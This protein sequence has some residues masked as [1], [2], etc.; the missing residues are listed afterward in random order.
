LDS[1][2]PLEKSKA[3]QSFAALFLLSYCPQLF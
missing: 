1:G 3:Q 2:K